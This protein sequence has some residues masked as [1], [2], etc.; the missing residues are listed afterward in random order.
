[1]KFHNTDFNYSKFKK[2]DENVLWWTG[3][4]TQ[5]D[6]PNGNFSYFKEGSFFDNI[7]PS[8]NK[9]YLN[10]LNNSIN[11]FSTKPETTRQLSEYFKDKNYMVVVVNVK[12]R[13]SYQKSRVDFLESQYNGVRLEV[14]KIKLLNFKLF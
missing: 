5:N 13:F 14:W 7:Y 1:M 8:D 3:F 2:I 4:D 12:K 11:N 10:I 6:D 9:E